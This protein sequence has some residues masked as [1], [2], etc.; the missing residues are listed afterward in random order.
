MTKKAPKGT[1]HGFCDLD[2][3]LRRLPLATR[4]DAVRRD[5]LEERGAMRVGRASARDARR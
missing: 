2:G 1:G 5:V 3:V 4:L